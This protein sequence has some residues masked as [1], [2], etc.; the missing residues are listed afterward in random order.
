MIL[1]TWAGELNHNRVFTP[2][3]STWFPEN[4]G[5]PVLPIAKVS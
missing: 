2:I 3:R 1:R 4:P 5:A